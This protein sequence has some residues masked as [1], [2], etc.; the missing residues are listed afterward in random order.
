MGVLTASGSGALDKIP[1]E[2]VDAGPAKDQEPAA[3]ANGEAKPDFV[4]FSSLKQ[5]GSR[6]E[7]A[8]AA[9]MEKIEARV[10]PLEE[11]WGK[12]RQEYEERIQRQEQELAHLRGQY[13]AM[14]RM[15]APQPI[16]QQQ[17]PHTPTPDPEQ[18]MAEAEE[19]LAKNNL[20]GYHQKLRQVTQ[21]TAERI[22]D[23]RTEKVRKDFESKIPP[24]VPMEIQALM[25]AHRNVALAGQRGIEAVL[26]KDRELAIYGTQPGPQRMAKAF[27]MAEE[28]LT[29]MNKPKPTNGFSQD[30][31][32]GLAAIP[33][34]RGTSA[35]VASDPGPG[36]EPTDADKA[37]MRALKWTPQEFVKW[38]YPDKW[39]KR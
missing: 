24:Q 6:R 21:I 38:K 15:P 18:L 27:E 16:I 12:Q 29:K 28:M 23:E 17:A 33:T 8:E 31:A 5:P 4:P 3:P 11:G 7:R 32:A 35:P 36:Y 37:V 1:D 25:S 20:R 2:G 19:E 9:I 10:K 30:S 26:L 14:Q 34:A 22:A 39:M 13:E